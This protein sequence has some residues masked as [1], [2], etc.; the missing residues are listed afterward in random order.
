MDLKVWS[1]ALRDIPTEHLEECLWRAL[2]NK[3][4]SY[5]VCSAEILREWDVYRVEVAEAKQREEDRGRWKLLPPPAPKMTLSEWRVRH[6]EKYP[7]RCPRPYCLA[8]DGM[9]PIGEWGRQSSEKE[10]RAMWEQWAASRAA[11][12]S[13]EEDEFIRGSIRGNPK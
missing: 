8:C 4:D 7:D 10:G 6:K 1:H 11:A 5:M 13:S 9:A 2:G 12:P 3:R